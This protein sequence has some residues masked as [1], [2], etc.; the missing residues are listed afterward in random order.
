MDGWSYARVHVCV[1]V[2]CV[3]SDAYPETCVYMFPFMVYI[4]IYNIYIHTHL[5]TY[6]IHMYIHTQTY[7]H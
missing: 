5:C 7:I 3:Y 2:L 6:H 1:Y 4:Y